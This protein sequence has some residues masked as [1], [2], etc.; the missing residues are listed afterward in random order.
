VFTALQQ[1]LMRPAGC[2][3]GPRQQPQRQ[4]LKRLRARSDSN[5]AS[6]RRKLVN[7]IRVK[8]KRLCARAADVMTFDAFRTHVTAGFLAGSLS[9]ASV[10]LHK[11]NLRDAA[12]QRVQRQH[13]V[14]CGAAAC[15]EVE[16]GV[17]GPGESGRRRPWMSENVWRSEEGAVAENLYLPGVLLLDWWLKQEA[18]FPS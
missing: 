8:A 5:G 1:I 12:V 6:R 9:V 16:H 13:G 3:H 17:V 11:M 2:W 15:E 7:E 10:L 18:V 14:A 4:Q